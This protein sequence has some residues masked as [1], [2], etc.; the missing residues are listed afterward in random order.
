MTPD[1][2]RAGEDLKAIRQLLEAGK[3]LAARSRLKAAADEGSTA[4]LRRLQEVLALPTVGRRLPA[5]PGG[6]A[7]I[8][9]LRRNSETYRGLNQQGDDGCLR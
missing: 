3:V 2:K 5:Q 4:E 7:D 1:E 9:W 8:E 6:A